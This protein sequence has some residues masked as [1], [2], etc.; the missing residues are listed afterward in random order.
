MPA[1]PLQLVLLATAAVLVVHGLF[2]PDLAPGNLA[3]VLTWVHY[4]GLLVVALLA[5]GNL[6]CAGCPFILARDWGRR[7]HAPT[8]LWPKRLRGKWIA[9]VL[10][11]AVLFWSRAL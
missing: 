11:V 9:I 10:L 7:L 5:A 4:R 1:P 2:G 6:F 3:T 8:R